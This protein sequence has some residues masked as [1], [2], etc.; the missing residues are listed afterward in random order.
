M[1]LRKKDRLIQNI[2]KTLESKL[3]PQPLKNLKAIESIMHCKTPEGGSSIYR[4]ENG[5]EEERYHSC[6]HRS[7]SLC[8]DQA[9]AKWL[10]KTKNK[11]LDYGHFHVVFTLPHEYLSLWCYNEKWF[12]Q[13][14]FRVVSG[15][16]MELIQKERHH[17]LKPG[18]LIALHTWGRNLAL[19]PHLHCLITAGG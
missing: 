11:L 18:I 7:C 19:H 12:G 14:F 2:F 13:T 9:K 8:A 3:P 5:H 17:G 6:R 4:C 15:L 16:L 10:D 1:L